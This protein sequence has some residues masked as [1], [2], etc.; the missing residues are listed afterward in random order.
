MRVANRAN[1]STK[2][3]VTSTPKA[4][5]QK[6]FKDERGDPFKHSSCDTCGSLTFGN[7]GNLVFKCTKCGAVAFH[8]YTERDL[9]ILRRRV[10]NADGIG[11][12]RV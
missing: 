8:Y 1:R 4:R 9:F 10:R 7:A 12:V 3:T 5:S 2:P 11:A 6:T